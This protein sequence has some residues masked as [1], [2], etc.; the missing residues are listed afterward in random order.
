MR[1]QDAVPDEIEVIPEGSLSRSNSRANL[2][3][4]LTP[5]GTPMPKMVVEKVDPSW[6]S[7]GDVPGTAAYEI[8]RADAAPDVVLKAPEPGKKS[9]VLTSADPPNDFGNVPIPET[10]ISRV[11]SE[12]AHGEVPGSAAFNQ[13]KRDA[14]PD[15]ME[16][17]EDPPGK[18]TSF[19]INSGGRLTESESPTSSTSRSTH[20]SHVRRKESLSMN[21]GNVDNDDIYAED[22]GFGDDFDD[23]K[24]D[25]QRG[26]DDFGD[27]DD[28]FEEPMAADEEE[29][30]ETPGKASFSSP[31]PS[32]VSSLSTIAI[33]YHFLQAI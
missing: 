15:T 19:A 32:F 16:K 10:V 26:D 14:T 24:E 25:E 18:D 20:R 21:S 33:Q 28:G 6:P 11:D 5:G 31:L 17:V 9:S 29:S 4:P 7:H 23:F 8:R 12:P 2:Q 13:R 3:R 27:F 1:R 30:T 22:G